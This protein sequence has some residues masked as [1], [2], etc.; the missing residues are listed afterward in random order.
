MFELMATNANEIIG[1]FVKN[2]NEDNAECSWSKKVINSALKNKGK[3]G[4][5]CMK[6]KRF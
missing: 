1:V 3:I 6:K 2:I 5:D 4:N